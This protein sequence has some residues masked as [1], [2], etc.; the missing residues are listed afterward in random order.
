MHLH[1]ADASEIVLA[2]LPW[3]LLGGAVVFVK[4]LLWLYR[5]VDPD[6]GC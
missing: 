4:A 3:V 1:D 2:S 5:E 6:A